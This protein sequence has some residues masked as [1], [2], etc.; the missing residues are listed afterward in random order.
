LFKMYEAGRI[1]PVVSQSFALADAVAALNAL[2]TRKTV[3]K[4]VL[5]IG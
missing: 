5:K 1:K 3:G 2:A 4:V